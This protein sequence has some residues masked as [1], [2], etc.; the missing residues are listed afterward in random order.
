MLLSEFTG[1]VNIGNPVETSIL[2]FANIINE[3]TG[4]T[5]G[6]EY[7]P[8]N[9]IQGDPQRRKPDISRAR[10]VLNWEPQFSLEE[11]LRRTIPYFREKLSLQ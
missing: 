10:K 6:I 2:E 1:P 5:A 9:R 7:M 3:M 4:N 11:G 8:K